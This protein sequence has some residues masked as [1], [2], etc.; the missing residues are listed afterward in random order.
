MASILFRNTLKGLTTPLTRRSITTTSVR[1]SSDPLI[2]HIN[3]EAQPG[4]VILL[5]NIFFNLLNL[6]YS[7]FTIVELTI[8]YQEQIQIGFR[9]DPLLW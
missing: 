2:G 7:F 1:Q 3:Q 4:A 6:F 5:F 9:N 8:Q